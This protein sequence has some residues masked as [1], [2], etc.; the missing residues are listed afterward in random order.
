MHVLVVSGPYQL[1]P[2]RS[3]PDC[4]S[5]YALDRSGCPHRYGQRQAGIPPMVNTFVTSADLQECVK[6]LRW[7]HLGKQRVEAYQIWRVLHG[8]TKGWRRHPAVLMWEGYTCFLAK[9]CNACIDEWILRGY[10]N[11]M[12]K[13]PCCKNP[14]APWWWGLDSVI[15]SHQASLN[16][17]MPDF[18]HFDVRQEDFPGYIWPTKISRSS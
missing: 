12:Q 15:K 7:K 17:K 4:V 10:K 6:S 18:Y 3:V 8:L 9:Y 11:T 14:A 2:V 5:A 13:L 16:R 1:R